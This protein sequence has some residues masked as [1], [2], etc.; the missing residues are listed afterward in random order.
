MFFFNFSRFSTINPGFFP[1]S[2]CPSW[3]AELLSSGRDYLLER[4]S[5]APNSQAVQDVSLGVPG[6]WAYW[7]MCDTYQYIL[8][9]I[10]YI[11]IYYLCVI[12]IYI[13]IHHMYI[14]IPYLY[15]YIYI[16]FMYNWLLVILVDSFWFLWMIM[17]FYFRHINMHI[18]YWAILYLDLSENEAPSMYAACQFDKEHAVDGKVCPLVIPCHTHMLGLI[19]ATPSWWNMKQLV[20]PSISLYI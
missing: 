7:D 16:S 2:G 12:Y 14:S 15:I 10:I 9:H 13:C 6:K 8:K 4:I 19:M 18:T 3:A 5:D 17:V 20:C 11:Y 1:M